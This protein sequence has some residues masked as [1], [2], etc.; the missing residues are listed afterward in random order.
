MLVRV[1]RFK[2]TNSLTIGVKID[3]I[4]LKYNQTYKKINTN[5]N[6]RNVDA[7]AF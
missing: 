7:K 1:T 3:T 4:Q 2:I 5:G 6:F